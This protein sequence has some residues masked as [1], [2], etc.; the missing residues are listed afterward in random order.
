MYVES[1]KELIVWQRLIS[2]SQLP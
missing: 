1:Y 2:K